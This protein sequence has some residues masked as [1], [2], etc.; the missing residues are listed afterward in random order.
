[1]TGKDK[2]RTLREVRA[3][4]A[5]ANDLPLEQRE[6]GHTGPCL[7]TCPRC[8]EEVRLLEEGL[9][10]R[11]RLGKQVAVAGLCVGMVTSLAGCALVEDWL[12]REGIPSTASDSVERMG[13]AAT[14]LTG[15]VDVNVTMGVPLP[16]DFEDVDG[17]TDVP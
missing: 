1:M 14:E 16:T 13:E 10:R 8:E 7:G 11:A 15:D 6:C 4:I 2:C 9:R 17:S 12:E 5:Q 3:R